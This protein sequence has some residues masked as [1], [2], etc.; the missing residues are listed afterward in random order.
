MHCITFCRY[1]ELFLC[2]FI[3]D[4]LIYP[5]PIKSDLKP[6]RVNTM[7]IIGLDVELQVLRRLE[8]GERQVDVAGSLDLAQ[9]TTRIIFKK[10][11]KR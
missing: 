5:C 6:D 3:A 1:F 8:A 7:Q 4:F 11:L 9:S 10:I 2:I